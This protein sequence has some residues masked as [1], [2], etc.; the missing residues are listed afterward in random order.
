MKVKVCGITSYDDAVMVLDQGVDALGF[1]FFPSSPRYMSPEDV[2]SIVRRL[3]PFVTTVGLFVNIARTD[4]VSEI[5]HR[6]GVHMIQLHGDESPDYCR[7]LADWPLIKVLRIGNNG[8][9][10]ALEDYS[11]QAFLLDAKDD[12]LFGG[13]GKSFDWSIAGS[14]KRIRPIILAGG[15]RPDNV[16]E[17]IRIVDPYAVDVCSGVEKAP[18]KKDAA[19]LIEFMNEVRNVSHPPNRA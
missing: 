2:R 17:A 12:T 3:P 8:I 7:K 5:A 15:L 16:R 9:A 10:E 13:T 4:Q 1:N 19:K 11:V 14:I 18:G 6:A